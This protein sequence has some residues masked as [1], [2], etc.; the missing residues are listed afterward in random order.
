VARG[1][2]RAPDLHLVAGV[3]RKDAGRPLGAVLED[4]AL[5][6]PIYAT[7]SEALAPPCDVFVE[8]TK[9]DGA[10]SNIVAALEAG[11]HVVVGTSGLSDEDYADIDRIA[12]TRERGVLACG[13]FALTVVLLQ[14]FAEIAARY[15]DH[16]E[17]ID[18]AHEDKPDVPSGTARELAYRLGRVK[19][20]DPGIPLDEVRGPAAA[21]GATLNG[22]QVHSVRLPGFVIGVEAIFGAPGQRLH[23]THHPGSSA[24]PYVD[25][26]LLAIRKVDTLRGVHRGLDAV[27]SW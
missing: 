9:P 21:R 14:R 22:V 8:F 27:M 13:N 5:K 15:L 3:A 10:K 16:F 7:A 18:T 4:K 12:R 24:E 17:I 26:T 20:P 1:I 25:G 19:R 2:A 6:A 11:A 23:L